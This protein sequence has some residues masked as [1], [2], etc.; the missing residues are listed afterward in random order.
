VNYFAGMSQILFSAAAA[1]MVFFLPN[2]VE[3]VTNRRAR[4]V[5]NSF[6]PVALGAGFVAACLV[7]LVTENVTFL[8]FQF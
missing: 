2:A 3:L 6:A 5:R 7:M 8:Y 1:C 4:L